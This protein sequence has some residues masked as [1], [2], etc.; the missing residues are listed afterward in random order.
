L[1][2][3]LKAA[4]WQSVRESSPA[5]RWWDAWLRPV[6][7]LPVA[8]VVIGALIT[9]PAIRESAGPRIPSAYYLQQHASSRAN[10]LTDRGP[11]PSTLL[12]ESDADAPPSA[13][14]A[15]LIGAAEPQGADDRSSH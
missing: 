5:S 10:P 12:D 7:A 15:A 13:T 14:L 8:A 11:Q 6:V 3:H 4:I 2:A 1:P 9:F